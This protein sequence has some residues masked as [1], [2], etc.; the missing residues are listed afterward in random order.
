MSVG[1]VRRSLWER[2]WAIRVCWLPV[3]RRGY[4]R[5]RLDT[6]RLRFD[7]GMLILP[8]YYIYQSVMVGR[9]G[10]GW[11]FT[12]LIGNTPIIGR[13]FSKR[14]I[15]SNHWYCSIR[16]IPQSFPTQAI[17]HEGRYF[18]AQSSA[19]RSGTP[20]APCQHTPPQVYLHRAQPALTALPSAVSSPTLG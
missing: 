5:N 11:L 14:T 10:Q 9:W 12:H 6:K 13:V 15:S 8:L 7:I 16:G 1:T 3:V 2:Q 19:T 18:T 4:E 17:I 20:S